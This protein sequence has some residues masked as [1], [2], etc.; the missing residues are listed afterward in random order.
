VS[1]SLSG[2]NKFSQGQWPGQSVVWLP[3]NENIDFASWLTMKLHWK[4]FV[5]C[6]YVCYVEP[7]MM[8][9]VHVS[10]VFYYITLRQIDM[11]LLEQWNKIDHWERPNCH[12]YPYEHQTERHYM[13][14]NTRVC[15]TKDLWFLHRVIVSNAE[16]PQNWNSKKART[17]QNFRKTQVWHVEP[18]AN[19]QVGVLLFRML[20]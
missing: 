15:K 1:N 4:C 10:R 12:A 14:E 7:T 17:G 3:T 9:R 16:K 13:H 8:K 19:R 11:A 6:I 20:F 5:S 18:P 2:G